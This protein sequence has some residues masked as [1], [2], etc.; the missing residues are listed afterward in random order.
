MSVNDLVL[1]QG[2]RDTKIALARWNGE[3]V[4]VLRPWLVSAP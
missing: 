3:P 4:G 1:V 2:M